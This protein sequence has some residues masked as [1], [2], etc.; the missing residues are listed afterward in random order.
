MECEVP[1]S[2]RFKTQAQARRAIIE[3]LEGWYDPHR[4]PSGAAGLFPYH[5]FIREEEYEPYTAA[6]ERRQA[7]GACGI[8]ILVS[9]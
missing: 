6:L 5:R 9:P 4:R 2:H 3:F 7:T 1:D 8:L